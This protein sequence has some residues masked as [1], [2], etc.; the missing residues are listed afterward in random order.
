VFLFSTNK[1]L[2]INFVVLAINNIISAMLRN[3]YA[4]A[5]DDDDDK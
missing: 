4:A 1:C 3:V 5:A 2:K